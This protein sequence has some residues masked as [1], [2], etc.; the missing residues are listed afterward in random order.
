MWGQLEARSKSRGD[1]IRTSDNQ[2]PKLVR[3]QT[4]LRP[5]RT[6]GRIVFPMGLDSSQKR[7]MG[8]QCVTRGNIRHSGWGNGPGTE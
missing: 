8:L 4:A 1:W 6:I 3:Y 7:R 2:Y 5:A